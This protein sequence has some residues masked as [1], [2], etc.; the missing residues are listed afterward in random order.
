[1]PDCCDKI[2]EIHKYL[3]IGKFKQKKFTMGRAFLVPKGQGEEIC[4]D[5][6]ETLENVIRMLA[7]G[8][9]INPV[10]KPLGSDWQ[11]PNAT[12]WAAQMYEMQ[13]ESMS[14]GNSTQVYE[15][16]SAVQLVQMMKVVAELTS[17]VDFLTQV[18]G[19]TPKPIAGELPVLF[20][21]HEE[22]KGFGKK[23][24]KEIDVTSA[25]TDAQVE[26]ILGKMF[27]PSKIP[28]IKYTFDP[29][30]ISIVQAISKL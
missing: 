18:L 21:I 9:I 14:N 26:K 27:V 25:K 8:L 30:S 2:E 20:T 16:H 29:N 23:P 28:Y 12:A 10:S 3:G 13:A 4:E 19:V 7:N 24:P 22:H 5:F 17:K 11:T 1:M 15:M 6:Y